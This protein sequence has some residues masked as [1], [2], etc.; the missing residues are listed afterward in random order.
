L[1]SIEESLYAGN[2]LAFQL[3]DDDNSGQLDV[4]ELFNALT[5]L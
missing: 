4:D 2:V 1:L 3:I 5:D